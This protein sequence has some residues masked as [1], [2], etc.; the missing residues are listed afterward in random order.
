[1]KLRFEIVERSLVLLITAH[2]LGVGSMLLF[3]PAW[4]CQ[5]FGGWTALGPLFFPRQS[6]IFHFILA[7]GYLHEYFRHR[8]VTIMVAAKALA[9]GF[10]LACAALDA[11]PWVVPFSG[12][13][14]GLMGLTIL[15]LHRRVL[16][17]RG[18]AKQ[19]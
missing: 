15:L 14:D 16:N 10:L 5:V 8:G 9:L 11:V 4:S 18:W 1:M 7:F 3:A 12:I 13:T 17:E 6:G 2:T 19:A